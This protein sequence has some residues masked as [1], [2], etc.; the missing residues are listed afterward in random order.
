MSKEAVY[1]VVFSDD[2]TK[3]L[4]VQRRDLPVWVLPGGGLDPEES[5]SLGVI[6]EVLEETGLQTRP[7]R[8]I[9]EYLPVNRLTQRTHFFEC[10]VI[11]GK[12]ALN[13][14]A[15]DIA[16]FSLQALPSRLAPP[17]ALWI[18]DALR[19]SPCIT[20]KTEGVTYG[21]LMKLLCLHPILI[22]RYLLTKI[23]IRFNY[24]K[25]TRD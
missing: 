9:A 17:F 19:D 7:L 6:R 11:G 1:G 13:P 18:Q 4:L 22:L 10:Q 25:T 3:V 21:V 2:R 16:F 8:Q 14:E 15:R 5:P 20:K 24:R 12:I 23:G